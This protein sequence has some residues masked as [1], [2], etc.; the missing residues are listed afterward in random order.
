MGKG[1][2]FI[3]IGLLI[4]LSV[5]VFFLLQ[6]FQE[7]QSLQQ[8]YNEIKDKLNTQT[9][10][11][12]SQ[13]ASLKDEKEKLQ[14][15]IPQLE[16][17]LNSLK[18]E[19][20]NVQAKYETL[21]KEKDE[22]VER[23]KS[24]AATKKE[25]PQQVSEKP[26]Q[27]TGASDEYWAQ[28]LK[29][30]A[31]LELKLSDLKDVVGDLQIRLDTVSKDKSDLSLQLSKFEQDNKELSRRADYNERLA[32]NLSTDLMREQ[33]D[34]KEI[35]D[36]I[37]FIKQE[38][39]SL[40]SKVKDLDRTNLSL[41]TKMQSIE[42]ERQILDQK[43]EQINASLDEKINEVAKVS[44]EIRALPSGESVKA[45][46]ESE[47]EAKEVELPP[48]VVKGQNNE[49]VNDLKIISGKIIAINEANNFVV[50]NLGENHAVTLGRKF[51]I[52]RNNVSIGRVE[53]I[54]ARK[55]ISAAD[56]IRF[57]AKHRMKIGDIVR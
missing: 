41:K 27:P 46:T 11:W 40:R 51:D 18:A 53:V 44:R 37:T 17:D 52:Y 54:Q 28:L 31:D 24:L 5:S 48:I 30:K 45:S 42:S 19:R 2:K 7:R 35:L 43:V 49:P 20:E 34:K 56:I 9:T 14:S 15:K 23:L 50:I 38:N 39:L 6:L 1:S 12:S 36:Q 22:L 32:S 13:L 25:E 55:N 33:K 21:V 57:D 8:N 26:Q 4:L 10:T 47:K 3:I 29:D 16:K